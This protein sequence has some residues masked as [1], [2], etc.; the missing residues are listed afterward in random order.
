MVGGSLR[1]TQW[2]QSTNLLLGCNDQIQCINKMMGSKFSGSE[3]RRFV[4]QRGGIESHKLPGCTSGFHSSEN[5]C[6]E[7]HIKKQFSF[8]LSDITAVSFINKMGGTHSSKLISS[9]QGEFQVQ[10]GILTSE[11]FERLEISQGNIL[12]TGR[13]VRSLYSGP[14]YIQNE[15]STANLLQLETRSKSPSHGCSI[16]PMEEASTIPVSTILPDKQLLRENQSREGI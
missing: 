15:C 10:L 14:V 7:P 4:N 5:V 6:F 12:S 9:R 8:F 1:S 13:K 16:D 3:H 2:L 11:G